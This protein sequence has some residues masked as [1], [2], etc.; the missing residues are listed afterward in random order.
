MTR[1]P[2]L[3]T[4]LALLTIATAF[5]VAPPRVMADEENKD[6][7]LPLVV[8]VYRVIDLVVPVP[9]Y[10]YEG[11]F[12]PGMGK[13]APG[14]NPNGFRGGMGGMSGGM[15]GGASGG[16]PAAGGGGGGAG[17]AGS[18]GGMGGGMF[19]VPD[20]TLGQMGGLGGAPAVP[21]PS[22]SP[23]ITWSPLMNVI[24]SLIDP[25]TWEENGGPGSIQP[26][27]GALA[28]SQ[29]L[30]V[31]AKVEMFFKDLRREI[32]T[33]RQLSIEA[34]WL[35]LNNE[36]VG[37]LTNAADAQASRRG[38]ITR[39][40]LTALPASSRY[41][42]GRITC[43]NG[44][45]VHVIS[46]RLETK[47][48]GAVPV[49]GSDVG[50][51]ATILTPHFG[52]LLQ[53]TPLILPDQDTVLIDLHSAVTQSDETRD[54]IKLTGP[55]DTKDPAV[56]I[57]RIQVG[58]QQLATS[59]SLPLGQLVLVGGMSRDVG[60]ADDDQQIYLLLEITADSEPRE[61]VTKR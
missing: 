12:L 58:A 26:I 15:M 28:I 27:G 7:D 30:P 41:A 21:R 35:L 46:G 54:S 32:G 16:A 14:V 24:T 42:S 56:Q 3:A 39:D 4:R 2:S 29:T 51:Q 57:D 18:G 10:P 38:E 22:I 31:H 61:A 23:R 49:V 11:T 19:R 25:D 20:G 37:T 52:A 44:Q 8:K 9:N 59:L 34:H 60:M 13:S 55:N 45:T 6:E 47:A 53:L 1:Y 43:I 33:L 40:R 17:G 36:Q 5:L 48:Q 50:Y